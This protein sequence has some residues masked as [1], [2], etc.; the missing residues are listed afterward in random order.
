LLKTVNSVLPQ[1]QSNWRDPD[2]IDFSDRPD[3]YIESIDNAYFEDLNDW[4]AKVSANHE[5]G[6]NFIKKNRQIWIDGIQG[7][8]SFVVNN[9][10]FVDQMI[11]LQATAAEEEAANAAGNDG[12]AGVGGAGVGGGGDDAATA[13]AAG[14]PTDSGWVLQLKGY[15]FF[16]NNRETG[17]ISHVHMALLE[18][19]RQSTIDL[20]IAAVDDLN[21]EFTVE[22]FT[23]EE[24]GIS[25]IVLVS[26]D[27][28]ATEVIIGG[29]TNGGAGEVDLGGDTSGMGALGGGATPGALGGG[30][31]D[32]VAGNNENAEEVVTY[33][34]KKYS[35]IVQFCWVPTEPIKR[36]AAQQ[37]AAKQAQ[38][39]IDAAQT[40]VGGPNADP[41]NDPNADPGNNPS[42]DPGAGPPIN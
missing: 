22:Q 13:T 29:G 8:A 39:A 30:T 42:G 26:S 24:M 28:D 37:L 5:K 33:K 4:W 21:T 3:F 40:P 27:D 18:R 36:L 35:F 38:D 25:H 19:L 11:A 1:E 12:G 15:H 32:G 7:N 10:E 20:P 6:L 17:D 9:Q 23:M 41:G 31:S 2:Q 34:A 16:N 14:G